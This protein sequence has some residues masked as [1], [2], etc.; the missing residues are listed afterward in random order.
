MDWR[1]WFPQKEKYDIDGREVLVINKTST[2]F[3]QLRDVILLVCKTEKMAQH[4]PKLTFVIKPHENLDIF[5]WTMAGDLI[6][7]KAIIY[8]NSIIAQKKEEKNYWR[9]NIAHELTHLFHDSQTHVIQHNFNTVQRLL[10]A[11]SKYK[12][13]DAIVRELLLGFTRKIF[14]EGVAFYYETYTAGETISFNKASFEKNY[15]YSQ[16]R[17][18]IVMLG[19]SAVIENY[20]HKKAARELI[21]AL[22]KQL[23][24]EQY[25]AGFYLVYAILYVDHNTTFEDILLLQPFEFIK[26]YEQCMNLKGLQPVISATSG[27]GIFDYKKVLATLTAAAKK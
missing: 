20:H 18:K 25:I 9:S 10:T 13:D 23:H 16:K 15:D 2:D 19:I 5:G 7:H 12:Y 24:I 8:L 6:E 11:T 4:F 17:I 22:K 14:T 1:S 21:A 26:K 27:D 3:S